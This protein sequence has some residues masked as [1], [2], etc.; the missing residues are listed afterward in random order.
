VRIGAVRPRIAGL[1]LVAVL[2]AGCGGGGG[3][4]DDAA[5][6]VPKGALAYVSLDTNFGSGQLKS[7]ES[8]LDK[9]PLGP[10]ALQT[11][12]TGIQANGGPNV[13]A[14][15]R[16]I[17]PELDVAILEVDGKLSAVGYTQPKDVKAFEQILDRPGDA[18]AVHTRISGWTVFA[19]SRAFLDAAKH[20]KGSLSDVAA[21]QAATKTFPDKAIARAYASPLGLQ[22]AVH[23][24]ATRANAAG[25]AFGGIGSVQWAAASL[26]SS[27]GALELEVHAK[28]PGKAASAP[29]LA[30]QIPSG[31]V[32]ALSLRGGGSS[33]PPQTRRQLGSVSRQLGVDLGAFVDALNGPLIAYVRAALPIPDVTIAARPKD[34]AKAK[35]AVTQLIRKLSGRRVVPVPTRVDGGVLDKVDLG[36]IA[37]YYGVVKGEL[38]VTDSQNALAELDG[39]IGRLSG[40]SVFKEARD[41]A[42]MPDDNQGFLFVDLKDALPAVTGFANLANTKLPPDVEANL[43]PLRS[44]LVYGSRDGAVE[45][46][47]ARVKT[48]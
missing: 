41:G 45:S 24:A 29:S 34:P 23:E 28:S 32:V 21:F 40:D 46:Y 22:A 16:T 8:I 48:N 33:L 15:K 42:G 17:G 6:I 9:F 36:S 2:A 3:P 39:S 25:Q 26:A 35:T 18:H 47:V 19:D 30:D 27:D 11:V 20:R 5:G 10:A 31:S 43:K 7:A 37:L 1:V 14:L 12:R 4:A 44:L 13:R 38:V